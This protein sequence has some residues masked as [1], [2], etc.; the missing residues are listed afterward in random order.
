M[1]LRITAFLL[2]I[3][4]VSSYAQGT[5]DDYKRAKEV[6]NNFGK[7]YNIPQQITWAEDGGSFV[8]KLKQKDNKSILVLVDAQTKSKKIIDLEAMS[9]QMS[10]LLSETVPLNN[11]WFVGLKP[12]NNNEIEFTEKKKVWR[13]NVS[14]NKLS[15]QKELND[16]ERGSGY[17]GQKWDDSKGE[18]IESPDKVYLA[19]IKN[20]NIY[21]R[22]K[23]DL[24]SEKQMTF[25]GSPGLYYSARLDWSA[26]SKKLSSSKVRKAEVRQLTLL[27]SSPTD[28]LQPKLQYR[29]YAKPG[30]ALSQY[31]P[32][33]VN[34]ESGQVVEVDPKQVENQFSL[35]NIRWRPDNNAITFE[36]NQRGHQRYDVLELDAVT[37]QTKPII[38]ETSKTFIDYSGKKYRKDLE[39][40]NEI[41]WTSERDGWNHLYLIDAKTGKVKNQITKGNWVVRKVINVNETDRKI[42]FEGSGRNK[43]EDP[44]LVRY[45]S[46]GLDGNGLKELSPEV[47]NHQGYFNKDFSKFIDVYSL[48]DQAPKAVLR[49]AKTGKVELDLESA[50]LS[51]LNASGWK[52]PEVFSTA[53][54][55]GKTD[56][57]GV[58][59]RPN[60]FDPNKKYPIVEYIYAGPHSSFVPKSFTSGL[61]GMYELAELG[62][63]VVQIDGM[64][65]SNR[66]KAFHDVAWKNLKDAGFPDRIAWMKAAAQKYPYM[67]IDKVGIYGTSAGGQSSTG[68][69]LFHPEFYKVA[70]SSCGCHDNRMDKIW[71]NE[72]WMGWPI[73]PQYAE[74]SNIEN[75]HRLE[76]KLMLIVG[77]LDDN[78]DPASTYQLVNQLIK[79]GKE[80]ELIMVPGM[81]HSSGGD[82]GEKKRRDFFVKNL[83][84][85]EPPAWNLY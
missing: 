20:N 23:A 34:V 31:Y 32:V 66:S 43:N 85:V 35:Y 3:L 17:W 33:I 39:K 11:S 54:R 42:I 8:Y 53:G 15:I 83:L 70:V 74:C 12:I 77:E 38:S 44:Y 1:K 84:G 61:S 69:V 25:D 22:K 50:D 48:V 52:A 45:Y 19:Y 72:Q 65:T 73:G 27:E 55:D 64:G 40:S 7:I 47:A 21:V 59:I 57:W 58:I 76:G 2:F 56:I 18:P 46:I 41:V 80:H 82:Y 37:G 81:G 49:D 68:A 16:N 28:Q 30:D 29:D 71:W 14:E 79:N 62:F 78:V 26:D 63:I 10:K 4:Q 6:R 24:K 67:D 9:E 13:W 75:A 36:Y 60:N 51:D 5:L